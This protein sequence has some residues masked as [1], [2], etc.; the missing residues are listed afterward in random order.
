MTPQATKLYFELLDEQS[1]KLAAFGG[2]AVEKMLAQI[3]ER[4]GKVGVQVPNAVNSARELVDARNLVAKAEAL[5]AKGKLPTDKP[6]FWSRFTPEG[7][8]QRAVHKNLSSQQANLDREFAIA[9]NKADMAAAQKAMQDSHIARMREIDPSF[10]VDP[11]AAVAAS[12]GVGGGPPLWALGAGGLALGAGGVA[13]GNQAGRASATEEANANN[14]RN[15]WLAYGGGL[16]TGLAAPSILQGVN[17]FVGNQGF[18]PAGMSYG[19][20]PN[21]T[22]I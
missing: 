1:K 8:A 18:L 6:G 14:T 2:P 13:L 5:A 12:K 11:A 20:N 19:E 7:R 16:A 15:K 22:G 3:A 17:S 10:G 4:A 9:K 21:F